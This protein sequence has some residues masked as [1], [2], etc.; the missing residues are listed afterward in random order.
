V[1]E[2]TAVK[3]VVNHLM[4][5]LGFEQPPHGDYLARRAR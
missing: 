4:A 1:N 2:T 3:A 5:S